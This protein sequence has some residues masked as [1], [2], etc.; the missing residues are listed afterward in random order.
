MGIRVQTDN[1]IGCGVCQ[2][3]CPFGAIKMVDGVP[4]FQENCTLC[5]AC[6]EACPTDAI[7]IDQVRKSDDDLDQFRDVWVFA[8]QR[9]GKLAGV[10]YELLGEGRKLADKLGQRL[11]CVLLGSDVKELARQ[12]IEYGADQVYVGEAPE[13]A[14]YRDDAYAQALEHLVREYQPAILLVGGTAAGRSLAPRVATRL[15][16]GLT[17]DCTGFEL[18]AEGN[19][20]QTRPTFGGNLMATIICRG[21]RPQMATVRPKVF[22]PAPHR[23]GRRGEVVPVKL[24]RFDLWANILE[25]VEEAGSGPNLAEAD[26]VVAG[27]RGLGSPENFRL[28]EELAE[29]LGG[30]VGASRA[31]VDAGWI[32]YAHQVGQTGRTVS[33]KL[34]IACGISGAI[35]HLAGMQSSDVIVAINKNPDAPIFNVATYGIVGDVKEVLPELTR[36]VKAKVG[37][38]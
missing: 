16:T 36:Q 35:Q 30:A 37:V 20:L 32:S 10:V 29:A 9:R 34:Y 17:A 26:I 13:L 6:V 18:D 31:V 22:A 27:G 11:G 33:P 4:E 25:V 15:R 12:L 1:C 21:R 24:P 23:P 3:D 14:D 2:R 8:E 5:G 7:H 38:M 19:L 28:V